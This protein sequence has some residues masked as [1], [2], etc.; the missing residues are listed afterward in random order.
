MAKKN[1]IKNPF[2]KT[3]EGKMANLITLGRFNV[4][5]MVLKST[6]DV[7]ERNEYDSHVMQDEIERFNNPKV[8]TQ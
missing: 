3:V 6:S 7:H 2:T 4:K 1:E 8:L 5:N